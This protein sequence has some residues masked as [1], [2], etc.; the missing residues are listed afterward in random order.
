[1]P[2]KVLIV[3]NRYLYRGGED[4]VVD[5]EINLLRSNGHDVE[6]YT[7]D[8]KDIEKLGAIKSFATALWSRKTS[9]DLDRIINDFR[10]DII[11]CHNTFPLISP[12]IYW[13]ASRHKIPIVQTLHNFRLSCIQAMFL[14]NDSLCEDC[15]GR[16]PWRGVIHKCYRK[17]L[18]QSLALATILSSHRLIG[19][20]SSKV[21]CYIALNDFCRDVFIKGGLPHDRIK[22]KPNFVDI[23][24]IKRPEKKS[25]PLFVG[26]LSPEKGIKLL[27]DA[28][29]KTQDITID[30]VGTGPLQAL[31]ENNN[32]FHLHGEMPY[33]NVK[34]FMHNA[35]F[36]IMPSIW[37]ENFPR[38]LVESF[39]IGCPVI[40]SRIG[41]LAQIIDDGRNGI[42]FDPESPED[43][44]E[45]ILWATANPDK[46]AEIGNNARQD[47]EKHYT[48]SANYDI[49]LKIYQ[50]A[51]QSTK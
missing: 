18:P 35:S 9:A 49:L 17:S 12:S 24:Y 34:R 6:L 2:A 42:L 44:K 31:L 41:A 45:K 46:M 13:A 26:R 30:V 32:T 40:A 47:Y 16:S 28:L 39:A 23:S 1:M 27:T 4:T 15:L 10:P 20:Y 11:H 5:E 14:R 43:L 3:H 51:I 33:D 21:S 38:T 22:V 25:N 7:R 50:D 8:N 48:P 19:T 36:L 37:Y 29:I